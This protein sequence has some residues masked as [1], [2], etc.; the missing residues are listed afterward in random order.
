[1][2]D[3][4]T[5]LA[6]DR[7]QK[8]HPIHLVDKDS[9]ED[10]AKTSAG[11]GSR[12]AQG[13]S[14]RRQEG[15]RL[16]NPPASGGEFEV[17][18]AVADATTLS[19]WCLAKLGE[20]L[21]GGPYKLAD[22]RAGPGGARLAARRSIASTPIAT[23]MSASAGRA[24]SSPESRRGSMRQFAWPK[25]PRWFA[26]WSTRRQCDLGPAE[27]EQA[28]RDRA[29]RLTGVEK[30]RPATSFDGLS[31]DRGGRRAAATRERAP[32]L[33]ELEWGKPGPSANRDRRQGRLLRQRRSR[34]QAGQRHAADEEGHGRRGAR[35]GACRPDHRRAA[36]GPA[37][38]AD[39]G[40]R[41][42]RLRRAPSARRHRH[43]RARA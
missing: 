33:I 9:F 37:A 38:P 3:F 42:C 35:A 4:A 25:R 10:W 39:S 6:A 24:C 32:R 43:S 28:V 19:P 2:T 36:A 20:S 5:L 17:V 15:L 16:R 29:E 21:A 26:T 31:D 7:G 11:R 34:H 1:M 40:G 41:K 27:L 13:A 22:G 18:A 30:S 23:R 14:L 12:A 8:A